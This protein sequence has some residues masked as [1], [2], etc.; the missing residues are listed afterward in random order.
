M[1]R[2]FFHLSSRFRIG[3]VLLPIAAGGAPAALA[4]GTA[5]PGEQS[6][7]GDPVP[8]A[9]AQANPR[10]LQW[11]P[12]LTDLARSAQLVFRGRVSE[13]ASSTDQIVEAIRGKRLGEVMQE[14]VRT[15]SPQVSRVRNKRRPA[16]SMSRV[17]ASKR[18]EG[19]KQRGLPVERIYPLLEFGPIKRHDVEAP[20]SRPSARLSEMRG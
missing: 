14:R 8:A 15:L 13:Q 17:I 12:T 11:R 3:V 6:P 1:T 7:S 9:V 2:F 19:V 18:K 10:P 16:Q 4:E 5:M 20:E